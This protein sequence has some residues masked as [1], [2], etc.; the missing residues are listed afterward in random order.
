MLSHKFSQSMSAAM[1]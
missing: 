1:T